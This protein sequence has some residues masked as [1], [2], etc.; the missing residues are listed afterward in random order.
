MITFTSRFGSGDYAIMLDETGKQYSDCGPALKGCF[1]WLHTFDRVSDDPTPSRFIVTVY[2][3]N[4]LRDKMPVGGALLDGG[5]PTDE[6]DERVAEA[7]ALV[8]VYQSAFDVDVKLPAGEPD[9]SL[10][11][12]EIKPAHK[13]VRRIRQ[14]RE[15]RRGFEVSGPDTAGSWH[16]HYE[17]STEDV[18]VTG[19]TPAELTVADERGQTVVF[20]Q[21]IETP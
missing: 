19:I 14:D 17:P 1:Q 2:R 13:R 5:A 9:W 8:R 11:R 12:L 7:T 6:T 15:G 16:V 4:G 18:N 3:R 21:P 10:S 20:R